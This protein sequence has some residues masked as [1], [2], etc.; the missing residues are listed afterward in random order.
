MAIVTTNPLPDPEGDYD[1]LA[2]NLAVSPLWR[3]D[4]IGCSVAMRLTP[5]RVRDG[6][7]ERRDDAARAVVFGDAFAAAAD[8]PDLAACVQAIEAALAAFVLAKGV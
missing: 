1:R 5:F 7:V 4:S 3:E 6:I 2:V 8:D